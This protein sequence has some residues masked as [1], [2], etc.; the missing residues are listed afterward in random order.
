MNQSELIYALSTLTALKEHVPDTVYV[1]EKYIEE[2][3]NVLDA[4]VCATG[5]NLDRYR[6]PEDE[7]HPIVTSFSPKRI[8]AGHLVGG[9]KFTKGKFG[10]RA[11]LMMRIDAVLKS[12]QLSMSSGERSI[13][14]SA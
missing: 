3:H 12:F 8:R 14:F 6:I 2:F 9:T 4:L 13:G 5:S 1:A 10:E 11:F 7:I